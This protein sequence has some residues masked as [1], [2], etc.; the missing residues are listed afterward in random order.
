[1]ATW[2]YISVMEEPRTVHLIP[3]GVITNDKKA[4]VHI[5]GVSALIYLPAMERVDI[6]VL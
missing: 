5:Y 1:M 6:N 3:L 4:F 2:N